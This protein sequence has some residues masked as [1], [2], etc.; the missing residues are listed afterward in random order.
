MTRVS[1]DN[2]LDFPKPTTSMAGGMTGHEPPSHWEELFGIACIVA[3]VL[4]VLAWS[5]PT[6]EAKQ[7]Y[8]SHAPASVTVKHHR[9]DTHQRHMIARVLKQCDRMGV[10]RKVLIASITTITQEATARNLRGGDRDSVGLFQIRRMHIKPSEGD[11]RRVPE[12]A[13]KWFCS[14]A[15]NI[16]YHH[17]RLTVG[18]L[19]QRVQRSGARCR[20]GGGRPTSEKCYARWTREAVRTHRLTLRRR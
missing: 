1:M 7:V 20:L 11:R 5:T 15:K 4:F 3:L 13:A 16:D 2:T 12:W 8:P 10:S 18:Q 9:A 14:R 17:P 19:S 6:A